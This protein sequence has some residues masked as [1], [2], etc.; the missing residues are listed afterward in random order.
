MSK[1]YGATRGIHVTRFYGGSSN[2]MMVQIT[3]EQNS[4]GYIKMT[5]EEAKELSARI[6]SAATGS[7]SYSED[8]EQ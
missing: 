4:Q 3:P 6:L 2:G 7:D 1:E 8:E 5:V